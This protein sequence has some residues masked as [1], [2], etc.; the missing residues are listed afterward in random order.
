MQRVIFAKTEVNCLLAFC[1]F[2]LLP[3]APGKTKKNLNFIPNQSEISKKLKYSRKNYNF[4][5]IWICANEDVSIPD[6]ANL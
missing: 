2:G 5:T 6:L 4:K 1:F 3:L